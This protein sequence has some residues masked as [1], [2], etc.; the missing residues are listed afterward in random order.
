MKNLVW[1]IALA[2]WGLYISDKLGLDRAC[3]A[4]VHNDGHLKKTLKLFT[5]FCLANPFLPEL[6]YLK[7]ELCIYLY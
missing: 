6:G 2:T 4:I 5:L 3:I 1:K 7:N